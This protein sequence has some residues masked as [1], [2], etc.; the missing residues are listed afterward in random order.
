[1]RIASRVTTKMNQTYAQLR[2]NRSQRLL[3]LVSSNYTQK[4][5]L[6]QMRSQSIEPF[7]AT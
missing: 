6:W 2:P 7:L 4:I 3:A 1:V 5:T